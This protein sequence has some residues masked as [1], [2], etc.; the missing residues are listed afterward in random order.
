VR[1]FGALLLLRLRQ[2]RA[3]RYGWLA[4]VQ[5]AALVLVA[6]AGPAPTA[7]D[8]LRLVVWSAIA[9]T[10]LLS[11]VG[12]V[13]FAARALP[14]DRE[15]RR[16]L[17]LLAAPVPRVTLAASA[18]AGSAL[19]A[20]GLAVFLS[21]A[22]APVVWL[23]GDGAARDEVLG[24]A[25]RVTA[26]AFAREE[27][28]ARWEVAIDA[29]DLPE[30]DGDL[31]GRIDAR[32][33]A[34]GEDA[35]LRWTSHVVVEVEGGERRRVTLAPGDPVRFSTPVDLARRGPLVVWLRPEGDD[36]AYAVDAGSLQIEGRRRDAF[37][38][39]ALAAF[40]AGLAA[41]VVASI[42]A[43]FGTFVSAP[44]GGGVAIC[45]ALVAWLRS[46]LGE[47]IV[48]LANP[49]SRHAGPTRLEELAA[50]GIETLLFLL[51]DLGRYE[52]LGEPLR[53]GW[54]ATAAP[55]GVAVGVALGWTAALAALGAAA[56]VV[57][58]RREDAA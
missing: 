45:A 27:G 5:I 32:R 12:A 48:E 36:F 31:K 29:A 53:S 47:A 19:F 13:S 9:S 24:A 20:L 58:G 41:A 16:I 30:H 2:A 57:H 49:P 38:E 3:G 56:A 50:D 28:A 11:L 42:A 6:V 52:A 39:Y 46:F 34:T 7:A 26:T 44:V 40:G 22:A 1:V 25:S 54:T 8:R 55:L 10:A 4:P 37:P 17:G 23:A 43:A 15:S 18:V 51:P 14:S 35:E 33:L 21:A